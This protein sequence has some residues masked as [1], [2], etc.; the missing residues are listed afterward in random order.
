M[1]IRFIHNNISS[2]ILSCPH[3]VQYVYILSVYSLSSALTVTLEQSLLLSVLK[4]MT[5]SPAIGDKNWRQK[6]GSVFRVGI[7]GAHQGLGGA[8]PP[9]IFPHMCECV[10]KASY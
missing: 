9:Q 4:P 1:Y 8:K 10:L 7:G 5:G 2:H 6:T 3:L